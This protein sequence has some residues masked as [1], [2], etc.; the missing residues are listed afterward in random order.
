[1][2]SRSCLAANERAARLAALYFFMKSNHC[3]MCDDR[4]EFVE[5]VF[6]YLLPGITTELLQVG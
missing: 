3:I 1:M 4:N 2:H 5:M 6:L